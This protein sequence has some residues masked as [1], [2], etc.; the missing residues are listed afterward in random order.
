MMFPMRTA[1]QYPILSSQGDP[2]KMFSLFII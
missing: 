1:R 2:V